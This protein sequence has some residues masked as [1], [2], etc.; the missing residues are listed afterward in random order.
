METK[1][2]NGW[3]DWWL[4]GCTVGE[5][6]PN[7]I[8]LIPK[9][10]KKQRTIQGLNRSWGAGIQGALTV[11]VIVEYLKLWELV[12]DFTLQPSVA[13]QHTWKLT[14]SGLCTSKSASNTFL[15]YFLWL[16]IKNGCWTADCLLKHG[17]PHPN[18]CLFC[19]EEDASIQHI[20]V[21]CAFFREI[22]TK[23][24]LCVGLQP[25]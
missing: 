20:L 11:Q 19:D 6:A 7:L 10:S 13:D 14:N 15:G 9:R 8:H 24:F 12:G 21:S 16:A 17:L 25:V 5:L 1:V 2:W 4:H 18:V 23:I 22:W 3:T